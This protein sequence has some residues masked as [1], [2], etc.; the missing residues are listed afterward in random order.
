[1][2]K[3]SCIYYIAVCIFFLNVSY[4]VPVTVLK[5][6]NSVSSLFNPSFSFSVHLI[7]ITVFVFQTTPSLP[8]NYMTPTT[9]LATPSL[10]P[11]MWPVPPHPVSPG[12]RTRN[13]SLT[14]KE[15]RLHSQRMELPPLSLPQP[16]HMMM[17]YTNAQPETRPGNLQLMQESWLGVRIHYIF[18]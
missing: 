18:V 11:V 16:R 6:F 4:K 14:E 7:M 2:W 1:M 5:L 3:L 9:G 13:S 10:S 15:W 12:S 8:S 17:V